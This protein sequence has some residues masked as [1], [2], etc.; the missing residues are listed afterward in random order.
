MGTYSPKKDKKRPTLYNEK[1]ALLKASGSKMAR[2]CFGGSRVLK[3]AMLMQRVP[4]AMNPST[5][6][7]QG[8]ANGRLQSIEHDWVDDAP[9]A[10]TRSNDADSQSAPSGE[11]GGDKGDAGQEEAAR[12]ESDAQ[13]LRKK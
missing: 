11:V 13:S 4:R 6:V 10:A 9:E 2:D 1:G 3:T 12:A 8:K 5:L 7:A